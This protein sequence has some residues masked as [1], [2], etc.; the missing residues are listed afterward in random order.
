MIVDYYY[1]HLSPFAYLGHNVLLDL[2]QQ[3]GLTINYK[4]L[5]VLKVFSE[6][7]GL[8]L[9]QR[10]PSRLAY[11][12]V[13]L[14]RWREVRG[15]ELNI[16][17]RYF[18]TSPELSDRTAITLAESGGDVGRF[19]ALVFSAIWSMDKD[20]ADKEVIADLI[21]QV[22]SDPEDVFQRLDSSALLYEQF[23]REAIE[24][25]V[26][27]APAYVL[28]GEIFWGQ[29]RLDLLQQAAQSNRPPFTS[30]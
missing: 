14:K 13:E 4:P 12:T 20:I 8:P 17:A 21:A 9:S 3:S 26:F 15:L 11:R 25:G 7:G 6:T 19:S 16:E 22:G 5:N 18:P 1:S 28:N 2:A 29:D 23:T 27:G 30:S 24:C 10:N